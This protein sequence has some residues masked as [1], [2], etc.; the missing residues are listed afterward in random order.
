[1]DRTEPNYK[2]E[3]SE[4]VLLLMEQVP[5]YETF[6]RLRQIWQFQDKLLPMLRRDPAWP[7]PDRS[8]NAENEKTRLFFTDYL[9][10]QLGDRT[11]LLEKVLPTYPPYGK[12][13]LMDNGWIATIKRDDVELISEAVTGFDTSHV[14]TADGAEHRADVVVLATGFQSA[15][16]LAPMDIR[17]RDGVRLRELWQDDNPFAYLG[18]A[19][20]KFPNFFLVGGPHTAGGHGGS[21]IFS[22]EVSISYI[23]Q[24]LMW[25]AQENLG[26]VEVREDVARSYNEWVDAEHEKLI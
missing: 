20:P 10:K 16:M 12:R 5:Y 3:T 25:M 6:Y 15:R 7:H 4:G 9:T 19:V 26:S 14:L 18:V 24:L 23:A 22:A 1:M 2:R 11:D 17:G 21:A 8:V 13:I